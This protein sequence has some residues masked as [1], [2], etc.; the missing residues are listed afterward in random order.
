MVWVWIPEHIFNTFRE[1]QE[2][3]I[4]SVYQNVINNKVNP[5][6]DMLFAKKLSTHGLIVAYL[7]L[8][9]KS[10]KP[11]QHPPLYIKMKNG[12]IY[13]K[14][15]NEAFVEDEWAETFFSRQEKKFVV[16]KNKNMISLDDM[17]SMVLL[18]PQQ[19]FKLPHSCKND[20][21]VS[22]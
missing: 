14:K 22:E 15:C 1:L 10:V 17:Y 19:R 4:N 7:R 13:C 11:C 18:N 21:L 20:G 16:I 3:F 5:A 8:F 12:L 9:T 6:S 2:N